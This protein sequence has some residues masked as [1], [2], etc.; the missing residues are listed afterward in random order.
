MVGLG[1][2]RPVSG[3]LHTADLRVLACPLAL[4]QHELLGLARRCLR[5][6]PELDGVRALV[7]REAL[8]AERDDLLGSDRGVLVERDERLRPLPP[9]RVRDPDDR[10]FE[11]GRVGGDRLGIV[12]VAAG[13]THGA[14]LAPDGSVWTWG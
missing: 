14:A 9:V 2:R 11:Y 4:A 8:P 7:V 5:Q 12:R 6:R 10:A 3:T 13:S 1:E